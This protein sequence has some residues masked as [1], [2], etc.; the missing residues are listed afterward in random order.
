MKE[1]VKINDT[2]K[3]I[4]MRNTEIKIMYMCH[5]PNLLKLYNHFETND[6]L[7][8]IMELTT[9]GDLS[10]KIKGGH[11]IPIEKVRKYTA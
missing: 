1:I 7:Y 4:K 3:H 9:G 10:E 8:L 5:H 11:P 2:P 6:Y